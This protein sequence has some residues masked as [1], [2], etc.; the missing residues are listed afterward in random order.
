MFKNADENGVVSD[1]DLICHHPGCG[2]R[3]SVQVGG[4]AKLCSGHAWLNS[5]VPQTPRCAPAVPLSLRRPDDG[6]NW[7]RRIWNDPSLRS[8]Y[9]IQSSNGVLMKAGEIGYVDSP[10]SRQNGAG[11]DFDDGAL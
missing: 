9:S 7:A 3:W 10:R 6:K 2:A 1:A 5:D 8:P 4:G 11:D